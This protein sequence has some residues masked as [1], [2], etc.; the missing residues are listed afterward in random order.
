VSRVV[1][2]VLG[3]PLHNPRRCL[4]VLLLLALTGFG[5]WVAGRYL[6]AGHHLRA[7]RSAAERYHS[8]EAEQHL[9]ECLK[10]WPRDP[11]VLLLAARTARRQAAY[12]QAQRFLERRRVVRGSDDDDFVL[13]QLLLWTEQGNV[14][15][16]RE[17]LASRL[18]E[19]SA[20]APLIWEALARGLVRSF[21][22][23]DAKAVTQAWLAE[24]P[25]NSEA[26]LL[27]GAVLELLEQYAEAIDSFRKALELDRER[28][29]ARLRLAVLLV[30]RGRGTEALPHLDYLHGKRPDDPVLSVHLA[31]CRAQLGGEK[32]AVELLDEVLARYPYYPSALMERGRLTLRAGQPERAEDFLRKAVR[33]DPSDHDAH[34]QLY[35]CLEQLG[36]ANDARLVHARLTQLET[37]GKAVRDLL[38]AKPG[39]VPADPALYFRVGMISL[40]AGVV[41][42]ALR[43]FHKALSF[44]P[45]HLPTHRALAAYYERTGDVDLAAEHR[46]FLERAQPVTR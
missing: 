10:V 23:E 7:A 13:E 15:A 4:A 1:L 26:H 5:G 29:E 42:D 6:W 8:A 27:H 25:E 9:R 19:D 21:R 12:T 34:Y 18:R 22:L 31:R 3:Y 16:G 45:D 28:G 2:V 35:L 41:E 11:E 40:R 39:S 30:Q 37:D 32:R 46:Q 44:D 43:W 38:L 14:E 24:Q 20:T 33:A 36:R 17:F